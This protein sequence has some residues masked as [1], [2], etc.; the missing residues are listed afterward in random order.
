[1]RVAA[2]YFQRILVYILLPYRVFVPVNELLSNASQNIPMLGH[3]VDLCRFNTHCA[4]GIL[5][6]A[7]CRRHSVMMAFAYHMLNL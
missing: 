5:Y 7:L 3:S 4:E 2:W 6:F 1:M